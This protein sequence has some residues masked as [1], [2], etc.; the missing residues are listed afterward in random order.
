MDNVL[1]LGPRYLVNRFW[2]RI[3]Y[4]TKFCEVFIKHRVVILCN[5]PHVDFVNKISQDIL[6]LGPQYVE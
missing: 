3:H 5:F 1:K 6:M 2:M 4:L